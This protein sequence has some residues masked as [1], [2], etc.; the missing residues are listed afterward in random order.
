MLSGSVRMLWCASCNRSKSWTSHMK[1]YVLLY[2]IHDSQDL[3]FILKPQRYLFQEKIILFPDCFN[4]RRT[5]WRSCTKSNISQSKSINSVII[6][7]SIELSLET[8]TIWSSS[9]FE[10]MH[11]IDYQKTNGRKMENVAPA[12]SAQGKTAGGCPIFVKLVKF[13]RRGYR[14]LMTLF[15]V[16]LWLDSSLLP[17]GRQSVA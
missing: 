16:R 4:L 8:L 13:V 15:S 6:I 14:S 3:S 11:K 9:D 7:L 1:D 12:M 17:P 5:C 10:G 2:W